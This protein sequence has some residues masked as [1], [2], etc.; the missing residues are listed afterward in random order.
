MTD[1]PFEKGPVCDFCEIAV[2]EGESL[3]PIYVGEQPKPNPHYLSAVENRNRMSRSMQ[4][5]GH[6][7]ESFVA[8]YKALQSCPDIDL[9]ISNVV[10]EVRAVGGETHF[11]TEDGME[12]GSI[13]D[14]TELETRRNRDKIGVELKIRPKDVRDNPDAKV[15]DICAEKFRDLG[16]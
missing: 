12:H 10:D 13:P 4:I 9:N 8:L 1:D 16:E 2:E 14:V 15:C 5:L 7:G 3:E 6:E 11:V